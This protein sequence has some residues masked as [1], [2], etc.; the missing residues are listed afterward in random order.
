MSIALSGSN[1]NVFLFSSKSFHKF[2]MLDDL[3]RQSFYVGFEFSNGMRVQQE[4]L[5]N[6]AA[7][8]LEARFAV[9]RTCTR[10]T[11]VSSV[12]IARA[13]EVKNALV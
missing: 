8:S 12:L 1:I 6:F 3:K 10:A 5:E 4:G 9:V 13:A 7:L 11:P 2:L